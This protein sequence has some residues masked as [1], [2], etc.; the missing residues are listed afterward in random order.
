MTRYLISFDHGEMAHIPNEHVPAVAKA[1]HAVA[2]EAMEAGVFVFAGGFTED[3]AVVA[4]DGMV[5]DASKSKPHIGGGM[6]IDVPS[7]ED[8]L[9]WAAKIAL[10]CRCAQELHEV[11]PDP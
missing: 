6:I 8:A 2:Q 11:M 4:P 5:A 7:R 1:A 3:V 9:E 10:A